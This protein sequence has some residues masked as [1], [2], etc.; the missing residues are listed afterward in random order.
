MTERAKYPTAV[1]IL[2]WGVLHGD[3]E[4]RDA[5][6][7]DLAR[8]ILGEEANGPEGTARPTLTLVSSAAALGESESAGSKHRRHAQ[9]NTR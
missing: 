6:A 1:T 5:C 2:A 8:R 4:H 3:P 7:G 9:Q